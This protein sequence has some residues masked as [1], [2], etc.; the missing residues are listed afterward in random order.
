MLQIFLN[1][2]F[3]VD[4]WERWFMPNIIVR[5][6]ETEVQEEGARDA[7]PSFPIMIISSADIL[8]GRYKI[9][10]HESLG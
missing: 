2:K 9:T 6:A 7:S 10:S 3:P 4:Q 1:F 5:L 8:I